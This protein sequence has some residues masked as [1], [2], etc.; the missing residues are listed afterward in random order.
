MRPPTSLPK[1]VQHPIQ[2]D[3]YI[4]LVAKQLGETVQPYYGYGETFSSRLIRQTITRH[5]H[6]LKRLH[7]V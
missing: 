7:W 4:I 5:S 1:K 3:T 2:I 6:E